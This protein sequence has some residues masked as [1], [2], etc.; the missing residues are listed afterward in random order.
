MTQP[1]EPFAR[2]KYCQT[3]YPKN[4]LDMKIKNTPE[5]IKKK[6]SGG[7]ELT[8]GSVSGKGG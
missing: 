6:G 7:G 8:R 3:Q 5:P 2:G 4:M 1:V